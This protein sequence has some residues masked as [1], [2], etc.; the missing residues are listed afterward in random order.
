MTRGNPPSEKHP[1]TSA[2]GSRPDRRFQGTDLAFCRL[3][4]KSP[5]FRSHWAVREGLPWA[6]VGGCTGAAV[7]RDVAQFPTSAPLR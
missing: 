1:P 7:A 2:P 6:R 4:P 5:P 3:R